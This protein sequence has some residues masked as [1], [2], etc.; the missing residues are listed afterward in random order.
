MSNATKLREFGPNHV[1]IAIPTFNRE[2][3]VVG[4]LATLQEASQTQ[5]LNLLVA[6]NSSNDFDSIQSAARLAGAKL[7]RRSAN[8]GPA[9]NILRLFEEATTEWLIILGDDDTVEENFLEKILDE[10]NLENNSEIVAIKFKTTINPNQTSQVI[11]DISTFSAYCMHPKQFGATLLISSWV[12]RRKSILPYLRYAY[13]YCGLQAPHLVPILYLL[14]NKNGKIRYSEKSPIKYCQ[15]KKGE[16]WN[17]GLTYSLMLSNLPSVDALN[18][19]QV[20]QITRGIVGN[21]IKSIC[22]MVY[23]LKMYRGG[24]VFQHIARTISTVS[25]KHYL[26][27]NLASLITDI[28]MFFKLDIG[29]NTQ[30]ENSNVDRM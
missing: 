3:K 29:I 30:I 9:A 25:I 15:P 13:L 11:G 8:I 24:V 12:Y 4:L 28:L 16:G 20:R 19:E 17:V 21:S 10:L 27:V 22:G 2:S 14:L 5:R 26:V 6:D 1:T 18:E 7:L 23:R